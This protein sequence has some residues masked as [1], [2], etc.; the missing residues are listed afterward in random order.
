MYILTNFN[1]F[2]I[3]YLEHEPPKSYVLLSI[4]QNSNLFKM[5]LGRFVLVLTFA[6]Q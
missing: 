2:P 4:L 3:E 5:K 6:V 1:V